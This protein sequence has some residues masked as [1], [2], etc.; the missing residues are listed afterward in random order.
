MKIIV[1][2]LLFTFFT[3]SSSNA[4][5]EASSLNKLTM[6]E[7]LKKGFKIKR[8]ETITNL[9]NNGIQIPYKVITLTE[10]QNYVLC[11]IELGSTEDIRKRDNK[12]YCFFP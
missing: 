5:N 6:N 4:G 9:T 3:F 1:P 2:I 7:F 8:N 12:S 11:I 10:G